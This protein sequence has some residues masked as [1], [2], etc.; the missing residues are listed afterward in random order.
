MQNLYGNI[1]QPAGS[2]NKVVPSKT[3]QAEESP[4]II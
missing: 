1:A 3:G 4:K 2:L